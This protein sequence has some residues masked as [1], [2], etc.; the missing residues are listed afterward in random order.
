MSE[1][2]PARERFPTVRICDIAEE[3][4]P[5]WLIEKLWGNGGC[6]V[7]CGLPK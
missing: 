7:I 3:D 5:R 4:R 6:G 2:E 1:G